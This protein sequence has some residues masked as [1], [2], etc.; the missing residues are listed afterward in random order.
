MPAMALSDQE[1]NA[2]VYPNY[3]SSHRV[4]SM[5]ALG[6]QECA[7]ALMWVC[8]TF[9]YLLPAAAVTIQILSPSERPSKTVPPKYPDRSA[10]MEVD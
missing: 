7:G 8:V 5:S 2:V 10:T 6:D 4:L 3:L 9:A 1:V